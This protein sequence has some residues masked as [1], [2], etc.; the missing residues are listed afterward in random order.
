[1]SDKDQTPQEAWAQ[2]TDVLRTTFEPPIVRMLDGLD[3][4]LR[5][6]PWLYRKLS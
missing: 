5:R 1:M 2:F 6:W 3:R 4:L